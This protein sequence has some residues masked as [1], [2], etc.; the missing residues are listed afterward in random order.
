MNRH[1]LF[2]TL[3]MVGVWAPTHAQNVDTGV[4]RLPQDII[5]KG[6][7]GSPQ[8]VTLF[9]DPSQPDLYVERIRFLPT[10]KVMPH[11][12]PD[13][14]RAPAHFTSPLANN[15]TRAS[16]RPIP[17]ARYIPNPR[18][19]RIMHGKDGEVILQVTAIGPTGNVPSC[20][21]PIASTE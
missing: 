11:W 1:T 15:G 17:P 16:S 18:E 10:M 19:R 2:L 6:L 3:C 5:Y 14:V 4:V 21:K 9:G 7:A 13:A 8:H 12:H 20:T